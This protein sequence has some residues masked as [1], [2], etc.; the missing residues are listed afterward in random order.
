[1]DLIERVIDETEIP[2]SQFLP[3]HVNRNE[4]LFRKAITYAL[5]GGAV[6]FT[7]KKTLITGK[8]FAMKFGSAMV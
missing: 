4:M 5:K 3:T 7:G 8:R 2:V 6:D 1:M